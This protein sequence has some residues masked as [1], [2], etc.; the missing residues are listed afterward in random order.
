MPYESIEPIVLPMSPSNNKTRCIC[1]NGTQIQTHHQS[2]LRFRRYKT[3]RFQV[4]KANVSLRHIS[5]KINCSS[6][7]TLPS[8]L[9]TTMDLNNNQT[10]RLHSINLIYSFPLDVYFEFE[11]I[12]DNDDLESQHCQY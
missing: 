9:Q 10:V 4:E 11:S 2:S 8:K 6:T 7:V 3:S 1:I 5:E 12:K